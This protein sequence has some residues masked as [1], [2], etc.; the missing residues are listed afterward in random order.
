MK[1]QGISL[2]NIQTKGLKM[3]KANLDLLYKLHKAQADYLLE[4]LESGEEVSSGTL[5]AVNTF[6]KNNEITVDMVEENSVQSLT[7]KFKE[8]IEDN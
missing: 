6:L 8:L 2:G 7:Q 4:Y 1:P 3:A 5:A